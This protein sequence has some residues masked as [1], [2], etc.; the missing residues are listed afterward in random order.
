LTKTVL[1]GAF[2]PTPI[3]VGRRHLAGWLLTYGYGRC[4]QGAEQLGGPA[5]GPLPRTIGRVC[6]GTIE[7]VVADQLRPAVEYVEAASRVTAEE[8]RERLREQQALVRRLRG[9]LR[10]E[11]G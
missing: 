1:A 3:G 10:D 5:G 8:L 6:V 9:Q 2:K 4:G 11:I 7:C